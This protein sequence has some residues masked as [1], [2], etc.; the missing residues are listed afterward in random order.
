MF[1]ERKSHPLELKKRQEKMKRVKGKFSLLLF[2]MH[3]TFP[4]LKSLSSLSLSVSCHKAKVYWRL[5][6]VI[7]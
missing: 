1:I 6:R 3:F 2:S 7:G 4:F 5:G